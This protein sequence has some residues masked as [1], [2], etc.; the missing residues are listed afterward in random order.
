MTHEVNPR[1]A[2]SFM[3]APAT[4]AFF[5]LVSILGSCLGFALAVR[6][7]QEANLLLTAFGVLTAGVFLICVVALVLEWWVS[8]RRP[9]PV[10]GHDPGGRPAT[11]APRP[12]W[13]VA[14]SA[15]TLAVTLVPTLAAAAVLLT[16]PEWPVGVLL[17]LAAGWVGR[18][19]APFLGGRVE[20]GAST[21]RLPDSRTFAKER[22]GTY[23]GTASQ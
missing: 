8:R 16:R 5:G 2:T 9:G 6:G 12:R 10:L 19:L 4:L 1:P 13:T 23:V 20:P 11:V 17:L 15:V 3:S 21:C 14:L 7:A 18:Y 22:R